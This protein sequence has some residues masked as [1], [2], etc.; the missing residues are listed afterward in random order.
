MSLTIIVARQREGHQ[1][2][3]ARAQ[4]L[5]PAVEQDVGAARAVGRVHG[6]DAIDAA[7]VEGVP[8]LALKLAGGRVVPAP[9]RAVVLA[10]GK[11]VVLWRHHLQHQAAC[12][13]RCGMNTSGLQ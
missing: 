10:D 11:Q 9:Q 7:V 4:V 3:W 8:A 5:L 13:R 6:L 2:T 12:I 1:L